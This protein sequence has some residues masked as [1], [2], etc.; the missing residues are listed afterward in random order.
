MEVLHESKS[1]TSVYRRYRIVQC[2]KNK[3]CFLTVTSDESQIKGLENL[4][5]LCTIHQAT[6]ATEAP[7]ASLGSGSDNSVGS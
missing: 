7:V 4:L 5:K 6:G 2:V 1:L 3:S